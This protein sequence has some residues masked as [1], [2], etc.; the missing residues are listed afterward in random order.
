MTD[1]LAHLNPEQHA[2]VTL[3]PNVSALILAGAGS[4]KT[5]VLITRIAW[6]LQTAR[7][8]PTSILA[9]T[10]TNKAAK[11]M[12]ARLAAMLPIDVRSLWIGT[13]HGLCH[14][15]LR[16][17]YHE[18]GLPH[19]F[20]ILD[21]GDQLAAIKRL[22]KAHHIDDS[23]YPPRQVQHFI[24]HAKEQGLRATAIEAN[25]AFDRRLIE[26]YELYDSQC[27]REG[28]V[29]FAE[30]LL[31]S[32]ELLAR[33]VALR[34]HYQSRFAH[35]L[36]DE[37]Q[38]TNTL[39]YTWLKQLAGERGA[40]FAV[41]D[42][43]QSIYAF[44]GAN[45]GNMRAFEREFKVDHLIRLEQNYRSHGHILDTANA[46]IA[47]N[48]RRLGKQLRTEAG[49]GERV[50]VYKAATDRHEA[51]WLVDEVQHLIRQGMT[52][53]QIAVLYRSNAQSRVLEHMLMSARLPYR[54]YGGLRFFDRAEVKHALAYLRLIHHPHDDT[55]FARVVNFP[56]RGIGPRALEQLSEQAQL[57]HCAMAAAVPYLSGRTGASLGTFIRLI[58]KMRADTQSFGLPATV[59][60]IISASGLEQ[61]YRNERDGQDR[62]ENLRELVNAATA[63]GN[64]S[65]Y[66]TDQSAHSPVPVLNAHDPSDMI[67]PMPA[68]HA[69]N[70]LMTPLA[71]FLSHASLE[72]GDNQ[73]QAGQEAIQ[74]M[75]V[76]AAKGLE[77]TAVFMTGLEEGLFPHDN[78][79]QNADSLEEERR[80]M[81]V[82]I[83]RARAHLYLSFAQSRML[84]GRERYNIQSRFIDELPAHT[85]K[86]SM[87]T[88]MTEE[89]PMGFEAH[90]PA[91]NGTV[92]R[93]SVRQHVLHPK[94]GEGTVLALEG[95]GTDA[96]AQVHFV[97]QG[98]KWLALAVAGL[99]PANLRSTDLPSAD[100]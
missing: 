83:T 61:H 37:F 21:S 26:L 22:L 82:A 64:E 10:F 23:K 66:A 47:H 13:F 7:M 48:T 89:A 80:L 62:L 94:F 39:Q 100:S 32:H 99:Q 41:G 16:A 35:I 72:A 58:E 86:W 8:R 38:D 30:L 55:A 74:L 4:G 29:D 20:Q 2:A 17:H 53:D 42:D 54:V 14:R 69:A 67:E 70:E 71:A 98:T 68:E 97:R 87:F 36:V 84:Y 34:S 49:C 96:R 52:R 11:E 59:E 93:F 56:V 57:Y 46:L 76:H 18:A 31:R 44:R 92:A 63:F 90:R 15:M 65:G 51:A 91:E 12:I 25:D 43:D 78:N 24:N 28:M 40:V 50:H 19:T 75:T 85:L 79:T 33:E 88:A 60:Y 9:V 95:Q 81:Y 73:A 3:P 6:L 5:R 27:Q 1:L 77:F 45:V